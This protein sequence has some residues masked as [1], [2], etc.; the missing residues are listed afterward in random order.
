MVFYLAHHIVVKANLFFVGG[1]ATRLSGTENLY[2]TGGLAKASPWLALAFLIP[3]LSLAG[4]PPLSG[5]V[6][7]LG[8]VEATVESGA[9]ISLAAALA[10]GLFTLYSMLKIWYEAFWK[11]APEGAEPLRPSAE[12]TPGWAWRIGPCLF[13]AL[14]TVVIGFAAGPIFEFSMGAAE[15]LLDPMQYRDAVLGDAALGVQP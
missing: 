8:I 14:I 13:L 6:A 15:Q 4:L 2:A 9:W 12:T 11:D 5:F 10:V 1:L 3:A 7:K